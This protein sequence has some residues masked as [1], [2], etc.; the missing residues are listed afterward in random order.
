M[1]CS[2]EI[3][4]FKRPEG[5]RKNLYVNSIPGSSAEDVQEYLYS[6]FSLYGLIHGIQIY[7]YS[8]SNQSEKVAGYYGFVTF[9]SVIAAH[10]AKE[11]L[12]NKITISGTE[13][14]IAYAKRKKDTQTVTTLHFAKCQELANYYLGFNG[15]STTIKLLTEDNEEDSSGNDLRKVRYVCV[16]RIDITGHHLNSEGMGAW[17][18]TYIVQ[19][20]TSKAKAICKSKKLAYQRS[21]ENAFSK[22]ILIVLPN[23]KVTVEVDTT[24][25]DPVIL[26]EKQLDDS[27]LLKVNELDQLPDEDDADLKQEVDDDVDAVNLHIL[28]ELEEM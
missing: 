22:V 6:V 20:P 12:S 25:A 17:E 14:K 26:T 16:T 19:D 28:H 1:S 21:L 7:P 2:V 9:Y 18:E 27:N 15:W 13:C 3:I 24:Q 10:S 23:G 5:N 11:S 8:T 4:D